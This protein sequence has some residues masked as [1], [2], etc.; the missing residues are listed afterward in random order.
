MAEPVQQTKILVSACLMGLKVRYNGS[1]KAALQATLQRWQ[2]EN[3]LVIHCPELA[4][5]L[6]VPRLPAEIVAGNGADVMRG[7]AQII[8]N[9]GQDVTAHYQLAAWLALQAAQQ[10]GCSAALLTDGS[11]T[12]ASQS[13]YNGTFSG[14]RQPGM[15]VATALLQQH[16][17]RVF[18]EQQLPALM[19]WVNEREKCR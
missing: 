3:R 19:A 17:I 7:R 10:A 14:T 2:Q 6:P 13:I 16:G 5:G 11:P 9:S 12:C 1:E 4:A 8:E 15:G 18:S